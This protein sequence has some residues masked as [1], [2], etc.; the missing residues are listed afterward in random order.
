MTIKNIPG[1]YLENQRLTVGVWGLETNKFINGGIFNNLTS[2][3]HKNFT[4]NYY[5]LYVYGKANGIDFYTLDQ[6][7][8]EK[9][10]ALIILDGISDNDSF[11]RVLNL[12]IKKYL[13]IYKIPLENIELYEKD[14]HDKFDRI[15]TW[16]DQLVDNIKYF[17]NNFINDIFDSL[18]APIIPHHS[19]SLL[20]IICDKNNQNDSW[21]TL[22]KERSRA[23]KFFE[24]EIKDFSLYGSGWSGEEYFSFKG[25]CQNKF[26]T[27]NK[28]NFSLCFESNDT[29][30][31]YI[32][33]DIFEAFRCRT[34]PIYMG[35][36]NIEKYIDSDCF[37][38]LR[39]FKTYFDVLN[40]INSFSVET[41]NQ[42]SNNIT[43]YLHSKRSYQFSIDNFIVQLTS[44]LVIDCVENQVILTV[45]IPAFN[46]AS[47]LDETIKSC[48]KQETK[49]K[50]NIVVLDNFSTDN[51]AEIAAKYPF[52][53]Y[54]C[55]RWNIGGSNNWGCCLY[56]NSKYIIILGSDDL[57]LSNHIEESVKALESS[58]ISALYYTPCIW[59]D[60]DEKEICIS[61]HPG[62]AINSYINGRDEFIDLLLYDC[63]ITPSA[64][65]L[66]AESVRAIGGFEA[67][68]DGAID[69]DF[70]IRLA[71]SNPNFIFS[72]KPETMYRV[73]KGQDSTRFFSSINPLKDN[74]D[75][76]LKY[77]NSESL[78]K[79]P[80]IAQ[81]F[82]L[83]INR[84]SRYQSDLITNEAKEIS[85][86]L[87]RFSMLLNKN[88]S[89]NQIQLN[90]HKFNNNYIIE[91]GDAVEE[92]IFSLVAFLSLRIN[93]YSAKLD[94][95]IK[96]WKLNPLGYN[97]ETIQL[98]NSNFLDNKSNANLINLSKKID[99]GRYFLKFFYIKQLLNFSG[100]INLVND[101]FNKINPANLNYLFLDFNLNSGK[102]SEQFEKILEIINL[103]TIKS[104]I[105]ILLVYSKTDLQENQIRKF[106]ELNLECTFFDAKNHPLVL[107]VMMFKANSLI[108][109]DSLLSLLASFLRNEK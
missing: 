29:F 19:R 37:I 72:I 91:L 17:K 4:N 75:I 36:P 84:L 42:Y 21:G 38:N 40:Y 92:Q 48:E 15:Y 67:D 79:H 104:N 81:I 18:N 47:F 59:I 87:D 74:I 70:F 53:K 85:I 89:I 10:D 2:S 54:R 101:Y 86:L 109:S 99:M 39:N 57:I 28:Y 12:N 102:N 68:L 5:E 46:T 98:L 63:Y 25:S 26:D 44:H 45:G 78:N 60:A 95:D 80:N 100:V 96:A 77:I 71:Y 94:G 90:A 14:L 73:H 82:S 51:T 30:D 83:V 6:I 16:S 88:K 62:H 76:I 9:L 61:K 108:C 58:P 43:R 41:I 7:E 49:Y 23:I 3:Q 32:T 97:F 33:N 24:N 1:G 35:A 8:L 65:V 20:A 93:G 105:K 31:G 103:E 107:L 64:A 50:F 34:I 13:L 106:Q 69:W 27:L 56:S 55:N 66:R 11:G 52:V 22:R